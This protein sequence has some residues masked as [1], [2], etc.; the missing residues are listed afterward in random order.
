MEEK[1]SRFR[2]NLI[3]SQH[4]EKTVNQNNEPRKPLKERFIENFKHLNQ[5]FVG[6]NSKPKKKKPQIIVES[7][8]ISRILQAENN[9]EEQQINTKDFYVK[10]ALKIS[11]WT[12]LW[13]IFIKIEFGAVY[14]IVSSLLIIYLN[15]GKRQKSKLSAYSVFNPNLERLDGTFTADHVE[16]AI[17]NQF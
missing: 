5:L 12:I 8:R 2:K 4:E 11:L 13:I 16:K 3:A 6:D 7:N 17:R 15:T 9:T 14:F 10:L 1:L